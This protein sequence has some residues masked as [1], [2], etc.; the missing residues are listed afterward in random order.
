[1][2][3]S[4]VILK[5]FIESLPINFEPYEIN[6]KPRPYGLKIAEDEEG[7][8]TYLNFCESWSKTDLFLRFKQ[9]FAQIDHQYLT[10]EICDDGILSGDNIILVGKLKRVMY[11]GLK[12]KS[13]AYLYLKY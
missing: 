6:S 13:N 4:F 12:L 8:R 1:M 2:N 5:K 11:K 7:R 9:N 10:F 3:V